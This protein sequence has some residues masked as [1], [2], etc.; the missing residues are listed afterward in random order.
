MLGDK[1][2]NIAQLLRTVTLQSLF[3]GP[4]PE[5]SCNHLAH[6]GVQGRS[7]AT[8]LSVDPVLD[9]DSDVFHS[10]TITV[11]PRGIKEGAPCAADSPFTV[12]TEARGRLD[13]AAQ[14]RWEKT[15]ERRY[16]TLRPAREFRTGANT[17]DRVEAPGDLRIEADAALECRP[18]GVI[19]E[20]GAMGSVTFS[21]SL[22]VYSWLRPG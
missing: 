6:G 9:G 1:S 14:F 5:V 10:S 12:Y 19:E 8:S 11:K 17:V 15:P 20:R 4:T 21:V 16:R 3:R 2:E 13:E 18:P 22:G 7:F